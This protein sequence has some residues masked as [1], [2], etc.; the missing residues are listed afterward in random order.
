MILKILTLGVSKGCEWK[1][2]R[3]FFWKELEEGGE[4]R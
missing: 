1:I 4:K 2:L 3:S